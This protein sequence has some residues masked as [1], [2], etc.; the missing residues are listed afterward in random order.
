M[1]SFYPQKDAPSTLEH[2]Q[3]EK[4]EHATVDSMHDTKIASAVLLNPRAS[5]SLPTRA[6]RAR[7]AQGPYRSNSGSECML[8]IPE[9]SVFLTFKY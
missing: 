2:H 3:K 4:G 1:E 5:I 6:P 9:A 7:A 8:S